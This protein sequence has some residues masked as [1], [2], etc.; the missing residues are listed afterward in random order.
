MHT[1]LRMFSTKRQHPV[2]LGVFSGLLRPRLVLINAVLAVGIFIL[3]VVSIT[4]GDYPITPH[5]VLDVFFGG[6]TRIERMVVLEWRAP[7]SV[8]AIIIGAALGLSGALTQSLTRNGL[9]T[10]DILGITV[11]ASAAAVTIIVLGSGTT[12]ALIAWLTGVGIPIAAFLGAML[13]ATVIWIM[14]FQ[15]KIDTFRLIL[16]GIIVSALLQAYITW[17]M[18]RADINDATAATFWL[19]GSLNS[20]SWSRIS[21]LLWVL[22][23]VIL[24]LT[25]IAHQLRILVLGDDLARGLGNNVT[26]SQFCLLVL[27]VLLA[28]LAV[29]ASGPIGFVAFV[30][31]HI[32][33]TLSGLATPPL[34]GSMISGAF[35]LIFADLCAQTVFPKELP[36]GILTSAIGGVFLIYLLIRSNRKV[37]AS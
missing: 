26:A 6:G 22:P 4:I 13:T 8:A 35:L 20:A 16:T 12:S 9:A 19:N 31:P 14:S 21:W 11:G 24:L 1:P 7:R 29:A 30:A 18:T 36:V 33:R 32:S 25:W 2:T 3:L 15:R 10:P 34:F 37:N 23:V 17:I 28:A 5:G 27:S